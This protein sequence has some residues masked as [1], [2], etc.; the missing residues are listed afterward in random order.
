MENVTN[1]G[2]VKNTDAAPFTLRFTEWRCGHHGTRPVDI[3]VHSVAQARLILQA[4]SHAISQPGHARAVLFDDYGGTTC[5]MT[6]DYV[7]PLQDRGH[8]GMRTTVYHATA[9]ELAELQGLAAAYDDCYGGEPK[10]WDGASYLDEY[11]VVTAL[12]VAAIE[13][14]TAPVDW[15]EGGRSAVCEVPP[16]ILPVEHLLEELRE[17]AADMA[18]EQGGA[19]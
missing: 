7:E 4:I 16:I 5:Y 9:Q 17:A 10:Q 15:Y 13:A 19:A 6:D 18:A 8:W 2:E 14:A 12:D 3:P 1:M 11:V